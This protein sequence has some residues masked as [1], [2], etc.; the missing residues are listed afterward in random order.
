VEGGHKLYG[1]VAYAGLVFV[2][3]TSQL[4]G[5]SSSVFCGVGA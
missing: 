3:D 4:T 1:F 2:E 5:V